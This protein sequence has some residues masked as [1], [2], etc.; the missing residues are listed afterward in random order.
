MPGP[1]L[2]RHVREGIPLDLARL[3]HGEPLLLQ[4]SDHASTEA[5]LP[6]EVGQLEGPARR[7]KGPIGLD[8]TTGAPEDALQLLEILDPADEPHDPLGLHRRRP[9]R[10][11]LV[12]HDALGRQGPDLGPERAHLEASAQDP[13]ATRPRPRR[14]RLDEPPLPG[15]QP[16]RL[17]SRPQGQ[18]FPG[19]VGE[20]GGKH[21]PEDDAEGR[22][23]VLGDPPGQPELGR[24]QGG[25]GIEHR[26][27]GP[28]PLPLPVPSGFHD[29]SDPLLPPERHEHPRAGRGGG[30]PGHG[31]R[32]RPVER[33]RQGHLDERGRRAQRSRNGRPLPGGQPGNTPI[34][35]VRSRGVAAGPRASGPELD[36]LADRVKDRADRRCRGV[37][38]GSHAGR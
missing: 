24:R 4:A 26:E 16:P 3:D 27:Q 23:V 28:D 25:L 36:R 9:G 31:V 10:E 6:R 11:G 18:D 17:D 20:H 38:M 35:S 22:H 14:Q 30:A 37:R 33:K 5:G 13:H 34:A 7:R 32:E 19:S 2:Q 15:S 29:E 1:L 8:L 21:R 12:T